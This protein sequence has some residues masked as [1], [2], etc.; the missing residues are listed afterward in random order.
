M[1]KGQIAR[2][3]KKRKEEEEHK[4]RLAAMK[5]KKKKVGGAAVKSTRPRFDRSQLNNAFMNNAK[6]AKDEVKGW[7][8]DFD[9]DA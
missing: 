2:L 3:E 8:L 1:S 9:N 5:A 4:K 7:A 6:E